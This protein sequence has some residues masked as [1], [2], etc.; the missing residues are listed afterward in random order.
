MLVRRL[1]MLGAVLRGLLSRPKHFDLVVAGHIDCMLPAIAAKMRSECGIVLYAYGWEVAKRR[2]TP[3]VAWLA[4]NAS[5][6][7]AISS[8]TSD[9]VAENWRFTRDR[10]RVIP[11]SIDSQGFVR[12]N[13]T[14]GR[15]LVTV[16]RLSRA[17]GHKG[18]DQVIRAL[19]NLS[20]R[21]PDIRYLIVGDGDLRPELES[22]AEALGVR[23]FVEFRGQVSEREL[24]LCYQE[25]DIFIMPARLVGSSFEGFGIV[26]LEAIASGLAVIA[27]EYSGA[28]ELIRDCALIVDGNSV[29]AIERAVH[30]LFADSSL[31]ERLITGGIRLIQDLE[32][33]GSIAQTGS[34]WIEAAGKSAK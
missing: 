4:R 10:I 11:P 13:F 24:R 8:L 14:G 34:C 18:Q 16:S 22:L 33:N 29:I 17:E 5:I 2:K 26:Y 9:Y 21:Y 32:T 30:A 3:L 31:Q 19:P 20:K 28:W 23:S 25:S 1:F 6:V 7:I 15:N 12:R 27:G